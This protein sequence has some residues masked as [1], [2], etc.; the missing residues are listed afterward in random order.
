MQILSGLTLTLIPYTV[1]QNYDIQFTLTD[2]RTGK[3]YSGGVEESN[4]IYVELFLLFAL[5]F[6]AGNEQALFERIGDHL[7]DQLYRQGAFQ[8][9]TGPEP[10]K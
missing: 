3:K 8:S 4:K 1:T 6:T 10:A 9:T 5:P 7:Y 2:V